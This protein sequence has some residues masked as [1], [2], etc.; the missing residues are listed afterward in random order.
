VYLSM[1]SAKEDGTLLDPWGTQYRIKLDRNFNMK[2]EYYNQKHPITKEETMHRK[3][4]IAVSAGPDRLWDGGNAKD[5][6]ASVT[7]TYFYPDSL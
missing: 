2:I 5:N 3:R 6:V 1:E 4:A 7:L